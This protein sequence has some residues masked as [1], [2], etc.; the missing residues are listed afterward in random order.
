LRSSAGFIVARKTLL[1]VDDEVVGLKVRKIILERQGYDVLTASEGAE[2]L[3]VFAEHEVDAVVLDYFMPGMNGG[4][5]ASA[6]K[7][8]KPDV[9]I[10]LLSAYITL[11]DSVMNTVDAFI[12]KGDS[13][14]ILL[15]KIA[16]LTHTSI[17]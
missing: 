13:P 11:P 15:N 16:E 8:S 7:Q 10:I 14:E 5:V 3:Q 4:V 9:P 6:M 1:C 2:G 17:C 12:T